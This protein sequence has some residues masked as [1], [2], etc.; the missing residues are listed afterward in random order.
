ME[1]QKPDGI[2][3]HAPAL[4]RYARALTR[5]AGAAED[6]VQETL[7]VAHE[8]RSDL[9]PERSIRGWLFSVLHN[10][11]VDAARRRRL[12][13]AR[14]ETMAE[15]AIAPQPASPE[16]SAYLQQI[17][18]RFDALPD[19]QRAVLHLVAVEGLRYQEAADLLKI[20]VG[21]VMSR[22]S[23]ARAALRQEGTEPGQSRL[24]VI[25]GRD[26]G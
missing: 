7:L 18:E 11:F 22:L 21:T 6:L 9:D 20:P 2:L 13:A 25:G 19:G 12:E 5:D 24:R 16:L 15:T 26:D 14:I 4:R 8:R 23:R 1:Q 3:E 17:A 10:R